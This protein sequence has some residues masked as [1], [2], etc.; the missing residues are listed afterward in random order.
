MEQLITKYSE[1]VYCLSVCSMTFVILKYLICNPTRLQKFLAVF[2]SGILLG[3]LF[4]FISEMK[5][6]YAILGFLGSMGFYDL[7]IKSIMKVFGVSYN[8]EYENNEKK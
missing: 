8:T 4:W 7:I 2:S 1:V 3:I 6:P 5:L